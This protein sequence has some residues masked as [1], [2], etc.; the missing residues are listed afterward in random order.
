M[1]K[2]LFYLVGINIA[3]LITINILMFLAERFFGINIAPDTYSGLILFGI[4]FG[5]GGA[6]I[7]LLISRWSA[8]RLYK[9][10]LFDETIGNEK[11]K[12]VYRTVQEIAFSNKITIPEV[13]VYE[14]GEVNAFATG[15]TKNKSLV[16]V[17]SGLVQVMTPDEIQGVIGHEMTHILN[18]DMVTT[19]LLQ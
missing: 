7:N 16:A 4:V 10:Q 2:R 6:L 3:I 17:S 8:K 15:A 18:G 5:F 12:V 13:G 11:L 9:I 14:S 1:L 19:T